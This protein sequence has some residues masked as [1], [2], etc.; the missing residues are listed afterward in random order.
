M[1]GLQMA[2]HLKMRLSPNLQLTTAHSKIMCEPLQM[3]IMICMPRTVVHH[4]L[5][6]VSLQLTLIAVISRTV[7][8]I[9]CEQ[10]TQS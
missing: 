2:L 4:Q 3:A 10:C 1:H 5:G 6:C 8:Q 7:Q 9:D